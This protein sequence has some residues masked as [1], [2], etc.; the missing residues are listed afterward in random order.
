MP[1]V[2]T[3]HRFGLIILAVRTRARAFSSLSSLLKKAKRF[4]TANLRAKGGRFTLDISKLYPDRTL[5]GDDISALSFEELRTIAAIARQGLE[6]DGWPRVSLMNSFY[7]TIFN[8]RLRRKLADERRALLR[9]SSG[10]WFGEPKNERVMRIHNSESAAASESKDFETSK[11]EYVSADWIEPIHKAPDRLTGFE[12]PWR[13]M[14]D[15]L[16]REMTSGQ[17]SMEGGYA[18][19]FRAWQRDRT[20]FVMAVIRSSSDREVWLLN[21]L[22]HPNRVED[23][24]RLMSEK[25][26]RVIRRR[27]KIGSKV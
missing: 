7:E 22:C 17:S 13:K 6:T 2:R 18:W 9:K 23:N 27:F 25:A 26:A 8:L 3:V 20:G 16:D 1:F 19:R 10:V 21:F 24:C 12:H 14:V 15:Q 5:T 11:R 4:Q